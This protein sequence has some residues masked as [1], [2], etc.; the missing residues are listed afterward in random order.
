LASKADPFIKLRLLDLAQRY[1]GGT[2]SSKTL[3]D[4]RAIS[5]LMPVTSDG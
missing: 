4:I 2:V 1:D 5:P 3:K